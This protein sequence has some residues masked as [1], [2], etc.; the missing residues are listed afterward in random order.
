M[1]N[2][3]ARFHQTL[4]RSPSYVRRD[5]YARFEALHP[6]SGGA[7]AGMVLASQWVGLEFKLV[8]R[9]V[10][11]REERRLTIGD[12]ETGLLTRRV[13]TGNTHFHRI[14]SSGNGILSTGCSET[15]LSPSP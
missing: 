4:R 7:G 13:S 8:C 5:E 9:R 3:N 12:S 1:Q 11:E 2:L 10:P 15:L 6:V 14:S